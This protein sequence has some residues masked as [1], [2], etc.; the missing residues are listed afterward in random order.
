MLSHEQIEQFHREGY[1]RVPNILTGEQVEELRAFFRPKFDRPADQILPGDTPN[2]LSNI[3]NRYP[4]VRW[5]LFHGPTIEVLRSLLGDDYVVLRES[6]AH[7]NNFGA[8]HKD[9]SSQEKVGHMFHWKDDF[10]MVNLAFY[11][12]DNSEQYA[13]GLDVEP[14]SHL[15]SDTFIKKRGKVYQALEGSVLHKAWFKVAG[16]KDNSVKNFNSIPSKAGDLLIFHFRINHRATQ[17]RNLAAAKERGKLA[18]FL[19]ASRNNAH[20]EAYHEFINSRP[21]Y[22]YLKDFSYD[23]EILERAKAAGLNLV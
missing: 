14:G 15:T 5:L 10:L 17:P 6:S 4:E 21:D 22:G 23:A 11:L 3:Y 7:Y 8:W 13:G 9:T 1:I 18:I 16:G 19:A 2:A 20:V 12:Q